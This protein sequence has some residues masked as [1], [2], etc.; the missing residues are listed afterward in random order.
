MVDELRHK[1]VVSGAITES[2]Y[3]AIA[4]HI[5]NNG[6]EGDF[7]YWDSASGGFKKIAHASDIDAHMPNIM[8]TLIVGEY[9]PLAFWGSITTRQVSANLLYAVPLFIPRDMTVDRIAMHVTTAV[10]GSGVRMGIYRDAGTCQPGALVVDGG[11][12]ATVSTGIK[13]VTINQALTK[14]LYWMAMVESHTVTFYRHT[15][16]WCVMGMNTASFGNVYSSHWL[17]AHTYGAL[18]DP[19]TAGLSKDT[20]SGLLIFPRLASLD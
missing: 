9:I 11:I 20:A 17:V 1:D 2:E 8:Q 4:Q 16:D 13:T 7:I 5:L 10:G 14:G 12:A 18:P 6:V 15:M 19:F 3:E